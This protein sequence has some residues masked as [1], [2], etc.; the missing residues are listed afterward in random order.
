MALKKTHRVAL[1][2][3]PHGTKENGPVEFL[4]PPPCSMVRGCMP[5]GCTVLIFSLFAR[6]GVLGGCL[7]VVPFVL[8]FV[9][10]E[11]FVLGFAPGVCR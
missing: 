1:E 2:N 3:L 10:F 7:W 11:L 9:V 4:S 8:G 6:G 5:H